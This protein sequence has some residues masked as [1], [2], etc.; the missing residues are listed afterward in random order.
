M[1]PGGRPQGPSQR[2]LER[3]LRPAPSFPLTSILR[4]RGD[5]PGELLRH[6]L[7]RS[8]SSCAHIWLCIWTPGP[9][10]SG[11]S[12]PLNKVMAGPVH[13]GRCRKATA[14]AARPLIFSAFTLFKKV[15]ELLPR[16]HR[17]KIRSFFCYQI[18]FFF[19]L[20]K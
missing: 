15:L 12:F 14:R 19:L 10:G 2:N 8:W 16:K 18:G 20:E 9:G 5:Q 13:R 1:R 7:P 4:I 3:A 6:I 11:E 17:F